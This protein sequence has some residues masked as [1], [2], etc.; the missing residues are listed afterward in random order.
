[1]ERNAIIGMVGHG[2]EAH[3][4]RRASG[5]RTW[6]RSQLS[7]LVIG[8]RVEGMTL[9][10]RRPVGPCFSRGLTTALS[11]LTGDKAPADRPAVAAK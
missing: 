10:R 5:V 9:D 11:T 7:C 6:R 2:R 3:R 1:M 4:K 8:A